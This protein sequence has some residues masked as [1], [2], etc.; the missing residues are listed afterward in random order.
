MPN[1]DLII[2]KCFLTTAANGASLIPVS[3]SLHSDKQ[4]ENRN[5]AGHP[6]CEESNVTIE[7]VGFDLQC[8]H[9]L[10]YV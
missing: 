7:V 1:I 2:E 8:K 5:C 10:D 9:E 6:G 3:S 4:R